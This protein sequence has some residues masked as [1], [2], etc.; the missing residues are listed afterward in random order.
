MTPVH[1]PAQEE[2]PRSGDKPLLL[3]SKG[4]NTPFADRGSNGGE[5]C[6]TQMP[7]SG[8]V[9]DEVGFFASQS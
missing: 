7:D 5:L 8:A 9:V 1:D 6:L 2:R 3:V 4:G